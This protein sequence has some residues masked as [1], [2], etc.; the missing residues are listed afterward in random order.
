[1]MSS[2]N[3]LT[4]AKCPKCSGSHKYLLEVQRSYSLGY[5]PLGPQPFRM[6]KKSFTRLFTCPVT[7]EDFQA[8]FWIKEEP[9]ASI[10]A[11][12]VKRLATE[13]TD[14]SQGEQ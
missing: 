4:V 3:N 11:V 7:A 14:E 6:G 13:S 8:I 5:T 1:M 2:D 10:Q 9:N 12:E